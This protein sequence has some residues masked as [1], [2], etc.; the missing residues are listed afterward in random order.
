MNIN[1]EKLKKTLKSHQAPSNI[2]ESKP[3]SK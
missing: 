1:L 2:D 3:K